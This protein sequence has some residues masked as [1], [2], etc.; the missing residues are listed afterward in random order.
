MEPVD[1]LHGMDLYQEES[2]S[3]VLGWIRKFRP[4][5]V[6]VSYPCK[7]WSPINHIANASPQAKRRL[8]ARQLRERCLLQFTEDVFDL[9]ISLGGDALGENPL[10]S[11]SFTEPPISRILSHPLV[12]SGVSHGCRFGIEHIRTGE[13]LKKPT[14]WFSTS[15]E[16][17]DELLLRCLNETIPGHHKHGECL[18]GTSRR[19]LEN[20]PNKLP[21]LSIRG[22]FGFSNERNQVGLGKCYVLSV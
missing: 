2:R 7:W 18:G 15:P 21:K 22:M 4:R 19:M 9:Q 17:C 6:L 13:P 10:S 20:T 14:L 12:Y 3:T 16:I 5:L 1:I 11:M 8:R